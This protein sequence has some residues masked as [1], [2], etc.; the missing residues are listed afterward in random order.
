MLSQFLVTILTGTGQKAHISPNPFV[1]IWT[2]FQI[3]RNQDLRTVCIKL[4][5]QS[6]K[7]SLEESSFCHYPDYLCLSHIYLSLFCQYYLFIL[8]IAP[9]ISLL[10]FFIYL[11]IYFPIFQ[12]T[13]C[14]MH[15]ALGKILFLM[16][17]DL[18]HIIQDHSV[19]LHRLSS[20]Q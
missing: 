8:N 14:Y 3:P 15:I 13:K 4:V 12:D 10:F 18:L 5:C 7:K 19:Y 20:S 9:Q 17:S 6:F 16:F 2:A 11:L 1:F